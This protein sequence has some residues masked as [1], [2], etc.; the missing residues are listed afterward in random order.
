LTI[1][2]ASLWGQLATHGWAPVES[3]TAC[4]GCKA[5]LKSV[6]TQVE[7]LAGELDAAE[8]PSHR[9]IRLIGASLEGV[10]SFATVR[11]NLIT[12]RGQLD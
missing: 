3:M 9:D 6:A 11:G 1:F 12:L 2:L 10:Q 4:P 7:R 5:T 8:T